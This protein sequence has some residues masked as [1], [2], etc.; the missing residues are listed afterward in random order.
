[1]LDSYPNWCSIQAK[2]NQSLTA[3]LRVSCLNARLSSNSKA[4]RDEA[5]AGFKMGSELFKRQAMLPAP[6]TV[7]DWPAEEDVKQMQGLED[8]FR[9]MMTTQEE[10]EQA[11]A[12]E[13]A[14]SQSQTRDDDDGGFGMGPHGGGDPG[15][16]LLYT[17]ELH[18]DLQH[19]LPPFETTIASQ[20]DIFG[21]NAEGFQFNYSMDA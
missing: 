19:G 17:P 6:L 10:E 18:D 9:E 11:L 21:L 2:L 1:M 8:G 7:R 16:H 15:D 3:A 13:E 12:D 5:K 20:Y 4:I 14:Q